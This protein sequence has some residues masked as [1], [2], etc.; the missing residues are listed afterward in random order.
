MTHSL[1]AV[2][3][4]LTP[5][6]D[7]FADP[8]FTIFSAERDQLITYCPVNRCGASFNVGCRMWTIWS[9][10]EVAEFVAI[11]VRRKTVLSD[12]EDFHTWVA[13]ITGRDA[14]RSN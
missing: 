13:A 9:P 7:T 11:L 5:H 10:I 4:P 12:S 2:P 14:S 6:A 1:A 8:R 3:Q